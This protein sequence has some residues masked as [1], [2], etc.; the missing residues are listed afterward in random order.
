MIN[1]KKNDLI[2]E[3]L[4]RYYQTFSCT[5]D[6]VD[7]VPDKFND[8][9]LRYI[10]KNLK[11]QFK[12]IDKEDKKYQFDLKKRIRKNKINEGEEI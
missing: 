2:D 3:C 1:Y 10:F 8:K 11:K 9:I 6:T 5:L 7:Y 12:K 4:M